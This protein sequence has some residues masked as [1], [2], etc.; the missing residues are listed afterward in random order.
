MPM[1]VSPLVPQMEMARAIMLAGPVQVVTNHFGFSNDLYKDSR[2]L[3]TFPA[4][5]STIQMLFVAE[6]APLVFVPSEMEQSLASIFS[7]MFG[8]SL[9]QLPCHTVADPWQT[10]IYGR[11]FFADMAANY[12]DQRWQTTP[13]AT[14]PSGDTMTRMLLYSPAVLADVWVHVMARQVDKGHMAPPV[15]FGMDGPA[16]YYQNMKTMRIGRTKQTPYLDTKLVDG[17]LSTTR[18]DMESDEAKWNTRLFVLSLLP[19]VSWKFIDMDLPPEAY[20]QGALPTQIK[21][22]YRKW[23]SPE[24]KALSASTMCF[25]HVWADGKRIFPVADVGK[26]FSVSRAQQR[27][28]RLQL[29]TWVIGSVV[30]NNPLISDDTTGGDDRRY[31]LRRTASAVE[32]LPPDP[33]TV[34]QMVEPSSSTITQEPPPQVAPVANE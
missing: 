18:M 22:A 21:T 2:S 31:F 25:P 14:V 19:D 20:L 17:Y 12:A 1:L 28:G 13:V 26:V 27:I 23:A 24:L 5:R 3:V 16:G 29:Q 30:L 9:P 6:A 11:W 8:A 4:A 33:R 10:S 15:P 32:A 34:T 7:T